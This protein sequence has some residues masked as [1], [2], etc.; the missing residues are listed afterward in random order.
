MHKEIG[1]LI[2][3][4]RMLG[5][6]LGKP[7]GG[8]RKRKRK[9]EREREKRKRKDKPKT[10]NHFC[11]RKKPKRYFFVNLFSCKKPNTLLIPMTRFSPPTRFS[12][13]SSSPNIT[14]KEKFPLSNS[15]R[16]ERKQPKPLSRTNGLLRN[17]KFGKRRYNIISMSLA[18]NGI[19]MFL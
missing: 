8:K 15:N 10:M 13:S 12:S 3:L 9:R 11:K 1:P 6:I 17:T 14:S 2:R 19:I 7:G 5:E 18:L 4:L 16:L